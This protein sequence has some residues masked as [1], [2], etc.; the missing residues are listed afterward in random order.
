MA[1]DSSENVPGAA[2]FCDSS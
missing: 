2:N 1:A